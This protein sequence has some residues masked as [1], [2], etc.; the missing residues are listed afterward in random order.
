MRADDWDSEMTL[1]FHLSFSRDSDE[2]VRY[3]S[4]RLCTDHLV[5]GFVDSFVSTLLQEDV[6]QHRHSSVSESPF[7]C[8]G[9]QIQDQQYWELSPG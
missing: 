9:R 7:A 5:K 2:R 6:C 8:C 1:G 4:G 3:N